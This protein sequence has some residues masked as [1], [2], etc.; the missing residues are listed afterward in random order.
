MRC[1]TAG[2]LEGSHPNTRPS[3]APFSPRQMRF[4]LHAPL[5]LASVLFA[6]SST[7]EVCGRFFASNTGLG[8]MGAVSLMQLSLGVFIPGGGQGRSFPSGRAGGANLLGGSG[9]LPP[10]V[11]CCCQPRACTALVPQPGWLVDITRVACHCLAL[12]AGIM[13]HLLDMRSSPDKPYLPHVQVRGRRGS[14]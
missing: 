7:T 9:L 1:W 6:A 11:S 14:R 5:Q 13:C 8:C 3:S 4:L 10:G 2:C 12:P